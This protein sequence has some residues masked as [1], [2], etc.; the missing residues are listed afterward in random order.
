M[1]V[2][3]KERKNFTKIVRQN[4]KLQRSFEAFNKQCKLHIYTKWKC[5]EF[6]NNNNII[7]Q[8]YHKKWTVGCTKT[9]C[10][11]KPYSKTLED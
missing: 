10:N 4:T 11:R 3:F 2:Q 9:K 5:Y 8:Q 1:I 6:N 7:E